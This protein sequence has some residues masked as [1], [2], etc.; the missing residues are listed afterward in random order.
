MCTQCVCCTPDVVESFDVRKMRVL[1]ESLASN[2]VAMSAVVEV[3]LR[4]ACVA[5]P[6][7]TRPHPARCRI[8]PH[9]PL[10]P[11]AHTS[12]AAARGHHA[13]S[14]YF[15]DHGASLTALHTKQQLVVPPLLVH[16]QQRV[17][18]VLA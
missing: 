17:R 16:V 6:R 13:G 14:A 12:H 9:T 1:V 10:R 3:L 5:L 15:L 2:D 18:Q 4:A 7:R 11:H 8:C